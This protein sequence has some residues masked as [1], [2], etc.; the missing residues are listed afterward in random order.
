MTVIIIQG[1]WEEGSKKTKFIVKVLV[2]K[3]QINFTIQYIYDNK[4]KKTQTFHYC[5]YDSKK[6]RSPPGPTTLLMTTQKE[7]V[8]EFFLL[9]M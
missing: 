7:E 4:E 8:I 1:L 5:N 9:S 2:I 6:K 3:T